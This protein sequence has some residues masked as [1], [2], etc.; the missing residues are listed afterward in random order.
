MAIS[1]ML[2]GL[3]KSLFLRVLALS[4]LSTVIIVVAAIGFS[5]WQTSQ[6]AREGVVNLAE[7]AVGNS[8]GQLG[9]HMR[10]GNAEAVQTELERHAVLAAD[11][12]VAIV[13]VDV[14]GVPIASVGDATAHGLVDL[15]AE[16]LTSGT[17]QTAGQGY[18]VAEP[19]FFDNN[20]P[21]VGAIAIVWSPNAVLAKL[22]VQRAIAIAVLILV[23]IAI[24]ALM[25][26]NL[27]KT[28]RVPITQVEQA[29]TGL[30]EGDYDKTV[31]L[32]DRADEIGAIAGALETL[33]ARLSDAKADEA[34]REEARHVQTIVVDRLAEAMTALSDGDLTHRIDDDM[35]EAYER[36]R[37]DYNAAVQR[38][39]QVIGEVSYNVNSVARGSKA[40]SQGSDDLASRT[41]Q[42]AAA[43]EQSAAAI[44][45]LTESVQN[46]AQEARDVEAVVLNA[47][48]TAE[49]SGA[50]VQSAMNAMT[51]I[52]GSSA[53]VSQIIGLID[54]IAFQ[55]N[56]LALNAGV[57]AARAGEA[58]R[59][60][61]VV[62][63][64]VRALAQ[65]ASDAAMQIKT[66]IGQSSSQVQTGV[67]LVGNAGKALE[68]ISRQVASISSHVSSIAQEAVGQAT[69]L[70]EINEAV[71]SLDQ[72]TQENAAM[73][74]ESNA[75]AHALSGEAHT[76]AE[77]VAVFRVSQT[78][79]L[80]GDDSSD[81]GSD[82]QVAVAGQ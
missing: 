75:A 13:A 56:L 36:L 2:K 29:V 81:A 69:G 27:Q 12:F 66:L 23:F 57:E 59:G 15:G 3:E 67:E 77:L 28:L 11:N 4:A 21:P 16:V 76:I 46:T 18:I 25:K 65:R 62:A 60:F 55:T 38:M 71:L 17:R 63:S 48:A 51:D 79:A 52:E 19:V 80:T 10:F 31:P 32:Q 7:S 53:Q 43:L 6:I 8:A 39:A 22:A 47:C 45:T 40:I 41:E 61:A 58:G 82:L 42:Q 1:T 26:R 50:I 44:G 14:S 30:A 9:P 35:T 68:E 70:G 34:R 73:V 72:V 20:G 49:S 37:M 33:R 54:E 78:G 24:L 74:E 5:V 64:E